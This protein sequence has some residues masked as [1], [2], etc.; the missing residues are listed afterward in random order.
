MKQPLSHASLS[1]FGIFLFCMGLY[2]ALLSKTG[3]IERERLEKKFLNLQA[4]VDKLSL[5]N[6]ALANKEFRL[7]NGEIAIET[8]GRKYYLLSEKAK[9]LKFVEPSKEKKKL[10]LA[11]Y[12]PNN[13]ATV[14]TSTPPIEILRVFFLSFSVFL[15]IGVFFLL[16]KK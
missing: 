15:S 11:A 8:E 3:Y 13:K 7:Q 4:E 2:F 6:K 5:E 16:K 14:E 12:I 1:S 10:L 9:I